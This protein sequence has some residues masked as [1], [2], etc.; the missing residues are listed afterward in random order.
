MDENVIIAI[1]VWVIMGAGVTIIDIRKRKNR[2]WG[3]NEE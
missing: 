1:L 2:K 3:E